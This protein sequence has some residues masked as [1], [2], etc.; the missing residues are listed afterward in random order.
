M[1][2]S[3]PPTWPGSVTRPGAPGRRI[4]GGLSPAEVP[5]GPLARTPGYPRLAAVHGERSLRPRATGGR[6]DHVVGP[7]RQPAAEELVGLV[8]R[9]I[10]GARAVRDRVHRRGTHSGQR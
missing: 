9:V 2:P 5:A 3:P 10:K 1:A 8:D 4:S 6:D 7:R